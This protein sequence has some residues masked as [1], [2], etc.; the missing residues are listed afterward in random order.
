MNYKRI[1]KWIAYPI[2]FIGLLAVILLAPIDQLHYTEEPYF[3]QYQQNLKAFEWAV[4]QDSS[5]VLM[6]GWG[7]R[8]IM[9]DW[10]TPMAGYRLREQFE[11]AYDTLLVQAV[12][13][14]KGQEKAAIIS[15][16]LLIF[17]P[18]LFHALADTLPTLGWSIDELYLSASHTHS[19]IGG[20]IPTLAGRFIAGGYD[21]KVVQLLKDQTIKAL[22]QAQKNM[23]PAQVASW[24][25]QAPQ[26]VKNRLNTE[27]QIDNS[28]K[29]LALRK[30]NGEVGVITSYAAHAI[31]Q[32]SHDLLL[33]ADYPGTLRTTLL[34]REEIAFAMYIAGAV[35]SHG[36][37]HPSAL[38]DNP[39]AKAVGGGVALVVA[40]AISKINW[41]EHQNNI[42]LGLAQYPLVLDDLQLRLGDRWGTRTWVFDWLMGTS[43]LR[44]SCLQIDQTLLL[45]TPCDF[46]GELALERY[47]YAA[48]KGYSLMV[49]SFNGGYVGYITPDQY[50]HTFRRRELRDMNWTGPYTGGYFEVCLDALIDK[51]SER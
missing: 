17:P 16:D 3:E 12:A 20:W 15:I 51:A 34:E 25:T 10:K 31:T 29:G 33:S 46:S 1:I 45:G 32:G 4:N 41:E 37:E 39:L 30:S 24:E 44:I 49:N 2:I 8:S 36:P 27:G 48:S 9:P 18:V 26:Y 43:P 11:G 13:L 50:Y 21:E 22:L 42:A 14:Q 35:G 5:E 40:E 47:E 28:L 23:M 6:A 7:E 38:E 19:S